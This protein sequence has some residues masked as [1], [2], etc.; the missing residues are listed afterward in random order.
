MEA[1]RASPSADHAN[2]AF[3]VV[4]LVAS[5]GGLDA[6]SRV[7]R[8]LPRDLPSAI[9]ILQHLSGQGSGLVEIL[10][11]RVTLPVIWIQ[12]GEALREGQTHVAP[13]GRRLEIFPDRTCSVSE[14]RARSTDLVL[15]LLLRSAADSLG[16]RVL[17]VV[18]TGMG[19]DGAR[20]ALAVKRAGG[21]V[22]VQSEDTAEQPSMPHSAIAEGAASLVAPLQEIGA[23][24]ARVV[25]GAPLPH[26]NEELVAIAST[27]GNEGPIAAFAREVRWSG[28]PLGPVHTWPQQLRDLVRLVIE[29]PNPAQLLWGPERLMFFNEPTL[30]MFG[31]QWTSIFGRTHDDPFP[32]LPNSMQLQTRV[33]AG[34][35][36]RLQGVP[37]SYEVNGEQQ[38]G[39]FD[40]AYTPI[41]AAD[42][43]V[44][45][46][47]VASVD[48]TREVLAARRLQT[49][50]HL[51][52]AHT[53]S[54]R[55]ATLER[56]IALLRDDDDVLFACA[57]L[58]DGGRARADLAAAS[59]VAEGSALAPRQL[60]LTGDAVWPIGAAIQ[61][62][63]V[64]VLDD[65]HSRFPGCTVGT[66][67]H[68]PTRA[69]I[70]RLRGAAEGDPA[71]VLILGV[72]TRLP[73]DDTYRRFLMT[74]AET[75]GIKAI[76][77]HAKHR[78]RQRLDRMNELDRLKTEFFSN[79]S[80]EFRTPLTLMLGPL[81]E[82]HRCRAELP[83]GLGDDVA[84]ATDNT[85]RLLAL[86]DTLLDFSQVEAGRL[87]ARFEPIDLSE[88]TQAIAAV[89]RSAIERAGLRYVVDCPPMRE[90][91]W[92]DPAMWDKIVSN[93]LAN[94]LKFT[95][96][97]EIAIRL[98]EQN[99]HAELIV[100]DTGTGIP[101]TEQPHIFKRFHRART[102]RARTVEGSG[103]GLALVYELLRLHNGRV[104]VR[105]A[106][107]KGT[108][109]TVWIPLGKRV[110]E[111]AESPKQP[112][113]PREP[114]VAVTLA[115]AAERWSLGPALPDGVVADSFGERPAPTIAAPA[116]DLRILVVD[117][118]ADMREYLCRL[119]AARWQVDAVSD[120][121]QA[122]ARMRAENADLVIA[123][124][125]MPNLDGFALLR[126]MRADETLKQTPVVLLTARA[127]EESAVEGL[128]AGAADY[129]AK[130]FSP[131]E[132]MARV[133]AQLELSSMRRRSV[134]LNAFLVRFSNAV[135]GM[136]DARGVARRL[137]EMLVKELSAER[138]CWA[139]VDW[140]T[141]EYV[142]VDA[143]HA[144]GVPVIEGRFS[145]D[146]WEP[147]TSSYLEGRSIVVDAT[148]EDPRIPE[149]S[150]ARYARI[151]IGASLTVP[152]AV[153]GTL[154]CT[155]MVTQRPARKWKPEEIALA[156][157]VTAYCWAEIER[158]RTETALHV[159]GVWLDRQRKALEAA[160]K[161]A[162]LEQALGELVLT[163][164]DTLGES[165]RAAF[166]LANEDGT[167]LHH[168]V[169]MSTDY[170]RAVDGFAIGP[171]SLACG[172]ATAIGQPVVTAD[173][174]V[175]SRW[176]PW[177]DLAARFDYRGCWSFPIR[178]VTG[179][180]IGAMAIYWREPREVTA[181][182]RE[183][184]EFTTHTA[185]LILAT[186]GDRER[187]IREERALHEN[188]VHENT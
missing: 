132:L 43:S 65:L 120:G 185:S 182:E 57:Y 78:E 61:A 161:G 24:I 72:H 30:P 152:V 121:E 186:N 70:H 147:F 153:D 179:P 170:A 162:P 15:D 94:A 137:C 128:I 95:L 18:L 96:Q 134:Q 160:V 33:L 125:M 82:L 36:I 14:D 111:E 46:I 90:R 105:S 40:A 27:F 142:I 59:G 6:I 127:G 109:F 113:S 183:L 35:R 181:L 171:E 58:L 92:V 151:G 184:A 42:G 28:H 138:A 131:R 126:A 2:P 112:D 159:R 180:V 176:E 79:I 4:I 122:L 73:F 75:I 98:H 119:L 106:E 150:K 22:I 166:Y 130:P 164:T 139:E 114:K 107:D 133:S 168:V 136:T 32:N 62:S 157:S 23:L 104:R 80:H 123:D 167:T 177:R 13:P 52:S 76:E 83:N 143:F 39:W 12:D 11:R 116:S 86:V 68:R 84:L 155:L 47:H 85:R 25:R 41:Y 187:R 172:L 110:T 173:V 56:L 175:D 20:G 163:V 97:G 53:A 101:K 16:S 158:A 148:R 21:T 174:M 31:A 26:S 178:A 144:P 74:V 34:E 93:L 169:G 146:V 156:E 9:V 49:I 88:Q 3:D 7:L 71:G 48:R 165:T 55:R 115:R 5:A 124:V 117:D 89:F 81:E 69:T 87:H 64:F 19:R 129:I 60:P 51:A 149:A 145:L 108:T 37:F 100:A 38:D 141:H 91:V 66:R 118:N 45:G 63:G 154:R 44:A 10:R 188:G 8:D 17:A 102:S 103:I 67:N 29:D 135:R 77:S 99:G 50:N 54:D 140:S 1:Q